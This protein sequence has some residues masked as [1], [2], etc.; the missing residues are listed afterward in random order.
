MMGAIP[1]SAV[2]NIL[3]NVLSAGGSA[4][5]IVG[6]FLTTNTQVPIGSVL[7][8]SSASDVAS[9]FGALSTEATLAQTYFAGYD[10]ASQRPGKLYFSQ[11]ASAAVGAYLRGGSVAGLTLA[12]LQALSGTLTISVN[13]SAK[14]S[15]AISLSAAT[16]FSNAATII[17]AAFTSPG[18]T[19]SYDS[20]SGGFKFLN[21]TTGASSTMSFA[22]GTLAAGL[23]LTQA[24]GAVLSQGAAAMAPGTAMDAII[25]S[26]QDWVCFSTVWELPDTA[27]HLLFAAWANSKNNRFAYVGWTSVNAA[28]VNGDTSS[29]G[30][31]I[32]SAGYSGTA[33]MYDPNNPGNVAAFAMGWAASLNFA[34]TNGAA[35]A[36][37]RTSSN[38][39]AGV[40]NETIGD[41]LI[42]NGYNFVGAY[43]TANDSFTWFMPGQITGDFAWFD[44]FIYQIWLNNSLQLALMQLLASV[45]KI[46]YNGDGYA[47]I[48][49]AMQ[50]SIDAALNFGAIES[51]VALS[52]LQKAQINNSAGGNLADT[53]EQRGWALQVADPGATVRAARGSPVCHLWY[54]SGQSVQK[55]TVSS[56]MVQ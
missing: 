19:V 18:F 25:A 50:S 27:T 40:T 23:N 56:T 33:A 55:I 15:S 48:E 24:N 29:M 12:Q 42:A 4:L 2:V 37:F 32:T 10:G 34:Q 20:V 22:T 17:Q 16:S 54:T 46:P 8:F 31:A 52:E 7:A 26:T 6:L 9:Y 41:N 47:L 21:S 43:A 39:T 51:G 45:G 30:P 28:T 11:Y 49:A 13:G 5:D 1:A 3:P 36:A 38:L 53:V 35:T 14:T 44:D